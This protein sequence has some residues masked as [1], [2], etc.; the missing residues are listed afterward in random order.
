MSFWEFGIGG[1]E[2]GTPV[3]LVNFVDGSDGFVGA[4]VFGYDGFRI[5]AH[6]GEEG[7]VQIGFSVG[8]VMACN[9]EQLLVRVGED[10]EPRLI[11]N[12]GALIADIEEG[13]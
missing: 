9:R 5:I 4:I 11:G 7:V 13:G 2:V 8:Q 10:V 12:V 6:H 3:R 1:F